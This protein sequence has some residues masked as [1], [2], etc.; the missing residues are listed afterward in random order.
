M[1]NTE[2]SRYE[3]ELEQIQ[4]DADS[5]GYR[6]RQT[7][8]QIQAAADSNSSTFRPRIQH[9]QIQADKSSTKQSHMHDQTISDIV[10]GLFLPLFRTRIGGVL[11]RGSQLSLL[12]ISCWLCKIE[13]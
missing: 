2:L 13:Q 8:Q 6:F 4:T 1:H 11:N 5:D 7:E 9:I 3:D 10:R 12:G